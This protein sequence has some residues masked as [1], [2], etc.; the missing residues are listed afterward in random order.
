MMKKSKKFQVR[1]IVGVPLIF[2]GTTILTANLTHYL[3][4]FYVRSSIPLKSRFLLDAVHFSNLKFWVLMLASFS[5]LCGLGLI[6]AIIHP[7]KKLINRAENINYYLNSSDQ[8]NEGEIEYFYSMFDEVLSL[9]KSNLKEKEMRIGNPLLSRLKR[10]DQLAVLGF[11]SD[12]IAHEFRNP[13]GSIQGF[14]ELMKKEI[15]DGDTKR[16]YLNTILQSVQNMNL[17][18]EEL[19]EFSQPCTDISEFKDVNQILREVIQETQEEFIYKGIKVRGEFQEDL[20]PVQTNPQKIHKAF[21][22]ILRNALQF[23]QKGEEIFITTSGTA[24]GLISTGFIS[25][26]FY[27]KRQYITPEDIHGIFIPFSVIQKQKMG[28]GL[29]ISQNIISAHGGDIWVESNNDFGTSF[30]IEFSVSKDGFTEHEK[31]QTAL[32]QRNN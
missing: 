3:T 9:L 19:I 23:A 21:L 7:M 18:V 20:P 12:R 2:F 25:I 16:V 22:N 6:Y 15:K 5:F 8:S 26:R 14:A 31:R 10:A 30:I 27:N 28:L 4:M 29:S 11:I 13:L 24:A 17:L 32:Q 1:L